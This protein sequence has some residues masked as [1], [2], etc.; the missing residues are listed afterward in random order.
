MRAIT[1]VQLKTTALPLQLYVRWQTDSAAEKEY[2]TKGR[3]QGNASN[4]GNEALRDRDG[5]PKRHEERRE[6]GE[7]TS[8]EH[9]KRGFFFLKCRVSGRL[10]VNIN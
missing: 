8:M 1:T 5:R 4:E 10:I 6:L 2:K 7:F 9:Y 3:A